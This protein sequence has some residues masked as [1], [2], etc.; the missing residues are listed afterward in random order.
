MLFLYLISHFFSYLIFVLDIFSVQHISYFIYKFF[1][2]LQ[3]KCF[4]VTIRLFVS[5]ICINNLAPASRDMVSLMVQR[6]MFHFIRFNWH[7]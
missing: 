7:F 4:F 3:Q 5:L 2:I 6:C 1:I